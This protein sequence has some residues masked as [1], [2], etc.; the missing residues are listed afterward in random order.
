[1]EKWRKISPSLDFI[2][3]LSKD[4]RIQFLKSAK[5]KT[6]RLLSN[7]VYNLI[8]PGHCPLSPDIVNK[9][10]PMKSQL[11]AIAQKSRS[12]SQRK[13]DLMAKDLIGRL[14]NVMMPYLNDLLFSKSTE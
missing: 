2:A 7:F 4:Q 10:R 9:I 5:P 1:M 13:K 3:K 12:L 11:L 14:L 6:I 8:T